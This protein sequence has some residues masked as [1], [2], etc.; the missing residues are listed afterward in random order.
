MYYIK[1][2]FCQRITSEMVDK[3]RYLKLTEGKRVGVTI[4]P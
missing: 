4:C 2:L 1:G 3:D